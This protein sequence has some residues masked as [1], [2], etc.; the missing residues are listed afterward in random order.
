MDIQHKVVIVTG[1]S[2][3]IGEATAKLLAAHGAQVVL[4]ARSVDKLKAVAESITAAGGT[5][6]VIP[7]DMRNQESVKALIDQT[8]QHF[9]RIDILINNAGQSVAGQIESLN[10]DY[11]QQVIDLNV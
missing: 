8:V 10:L 9:G 1:A 3:G 4:A 11:F 7:T 5:A 6:I 2:E